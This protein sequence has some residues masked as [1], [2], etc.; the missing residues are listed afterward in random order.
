MIYLP[1]PIFNPEI[2]SD[3][4][5]NSKTKLSRRSTIGKYFVNTGAYYD[6]DNLPFQ[7][8]LTVAKNLY[9]IAEAEKA[10]STPYG[11]FQDFRLVVSE[12]IYQP[13]SNETLS[14]GSIN[15]LRNLGRCIVYEVYNNKGKLDVENTYEVA[16][17]LKH[18]TRFDK[19]ILD[20]D[21]YGDELHACI[22]LQMPQIK[23]GFNVTF[24]QE[25]QT[26]YNNTIQTNG[27]FVE[28]I[29]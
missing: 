13:E 1:D 10:M 26:Q 23:S 16:D 7:T 12:G 8:R 21:D 19:L 22:I 28:T 20:Y 6:F 29:R 5:L 9:L 4:E 2:L 24:R 27:E 11:P 18:N 17:Y 15:F 14:K 3:A 25:I